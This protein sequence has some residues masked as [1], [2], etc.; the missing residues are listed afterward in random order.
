[1]TGLLRTSDSDV[2]EVELKLQL[3]ESGAS[4]VH[5]W[6]VARGGRRERLR[7]RYFDTAGRSLAASG[8]AL[9]LRYERGR[10]VQTLKA[11]LPGAITRFE[12]EVVVQRGQPDTPPSLDPAR[13]QGTEAAPLL[14]RALERAGPDGLI[15]HFE[16]DI[17]R[18]AVR[19]RSRRG[20]VE[21]CFDA[22]LI[23]APGRQPLPVCEIE[24]ELVKGSPLAVTDVARQVI[25]AHPCWVDPA[26]KAERGHRLSAGRGQSGAAKARSVGIDPQNDA[27]AAARL[28]TH[29]CRRQLLANLASIASGESED[30]EYV[31]QARVALRR[32]R[33]TIRLFDAAPLRNLDAPARALA[34][35]L[36]LT[37]ERDVLLESVA[38]ALAQAGAPTTDLATLANAA[39]ARNVV[40]HRDHQF[41]VVDLLA[42]ELVMARSVAPVVAPAGPQLIARLSRWHHQVRRDA[43]LFSTLDD[44]L[45]HRLRRR[46]KRL[47]YGI[48]FCRALC[49]NKRYRRFLQTLS[50][51]Q[52]ALGRYNDLIEALASYRAQIDADPRAW[53]AVGWLTA[54][55]KAQSSRC[56]TA[57][58]A[59]RQSKA[60]WKRRYLAPP[61]VIAPSAEAADSPAALTPIATPATLADAPPERPL[62]EPVKPT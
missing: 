28:V 59:L 13:H 6:V 49:S 41:F 56:E 55:A 16:T 21:V 54:E 31:H 14:M 46:M 48:E 12:H 52:E 10:W 15:N 26:T 1:M 5:D 23:A 61:P 18:T 39:D 25:R 51:A 62:H 7:A 24:V 34:Q 3:D 36:G 29:E 20:E 43:R 44:D 37:R 53:F 47:R 8:M 9:R 60:P 17:R 40:R 19:F 32:L 22:G 30:P 11:A 42:G 50:E 33:T 35:A 38:P 4:A 45:R 27:L 2:T 57:L 58:A